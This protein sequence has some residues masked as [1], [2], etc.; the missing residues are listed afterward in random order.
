MVNLEKDLHARK[1]EDMVISFIA[2][3]MKNKDSVGHISRHKFLFLLPSVFHLF[4]DLL[5]NKH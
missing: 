3:H 1:V 2:R 4:H 5:R